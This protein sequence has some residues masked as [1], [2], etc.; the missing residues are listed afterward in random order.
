MG[1]QVFEIARPIVEEVMGWQS[2]TK[3][4]LHK[5]ARWNAIADK[6]A[7]IAIV[8]CSI[9]GICTFGRKFHPLRWRRRLSGPS[10]RSHFRIEKPSESSCLIGE[11]GD[12][13]L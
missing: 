8:L 1:G 5:H 4:E 9:G 12:E 10:E 11:K 7:M 6:V 3:A 2:T 13:G